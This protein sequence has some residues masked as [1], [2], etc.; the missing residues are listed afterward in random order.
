M[1]IEQVNHDLRPMDDA[2]GYNAEVYDRAQMI[3]HHEYNPSENYCTLELKI[4]AISKQIPSA[5]YENILES[6]RMS[7]L[8][9]IMYNK[10]TNNEFYDML[11]IEGEL[12]ID[13]VRRIDKDVVYTYYFSSNRLL[14]LYIHDYYMTLPIYLGYPKRDYVRRTPCKEIDP[15]CAAAC[16]DTIKSPVR[17]YLDEALDEYEAH[18]YDYFFEQIGNNHRLLMGFT[19]EKIRKPGECF[20]GNEPEYY[21]VDYE[22]KYFVENGYVDKDE[23]ELSV[24]LDRRGCKDTLYMLEVSDGENSVM[25]KD[26]CEPTRLIKYNSSSRDAPSE[27]LSILD[28]NKFEDLWRMDF[29]SFNTRNTIHKYQYNSWAVE[30]TRA[31]DG[32]WCAWDA[33]ETIDSA[34]EAAPGSEA[35][36]AEVESQ[37][38]Q[39]STLFGWGPTD[40]TSS[41]DTIYTFISIKEDDINYEDVIE[42]LPNR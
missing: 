1:G 18:F 4:P 42:P 15:K 31:D 26:Y 23:F 3:L 35:D 9:G 37:L 25:Y 16:I 5:Q 8:H 28:N 41:T 20:T 2:N 40:D 14:H 7:S 27:L 22:S 29:E 17:S 13:K 10:C 6:L 34:L 36:K 21:I 12:N 33:T 19:I 32:L 38:I 39:V 11:D 24:I 30:C